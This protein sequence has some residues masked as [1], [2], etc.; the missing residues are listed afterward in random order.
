M[1]IFILVVACTS[2]HHCIQSNCIHP[3]WKYGQAVDLR[4]DVEPLFKLSYSELK[5]EMNN[6]S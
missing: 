4:T 6:T 3:V 2:V 1:N 5:K